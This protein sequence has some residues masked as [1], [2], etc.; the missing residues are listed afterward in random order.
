MRVTFL[1]I[2]SFLFYSSSKAFI[3]TLEHKLNVFPLNSFTSQKGEEG[4]EEDRIG[5]PIG[6]LPTVSSRIN[7]QNRSKR[8]DACD[9]WI[10]GAGTIGEKVARIW[11]Q[12]NPES[13]VIAETKSSTR[14]ADLMLLG[15][16]PRLREYR[17]DDDSFIAKNVLICIPPSAAID[18][19]AEL[20]AGC[21][22]WDPL[23][24]GN[25]VFT[26]S[27][28][29]Y[30]DS[31][32]NI[33]NEAFRVDS[34]SQRSTKM[35][36]AEQTVLSL[37][38]TVA[39]LAGLYTLERGAHSMWVK[40]GTVTGVANGVVNLVHYDDAAAALVAALQLELRNEVYLVCD[41]A[42]ETRQQICEAT[43]LSELFSSYAM[44]K[45]TSPDGPRGK[46]CD[47]SVTRRKLNWQPVHRSFSSFM[48]KIAGLPEEV[49]A[50][51]SESKG[52]AADGLWLPGD[53]LDFLV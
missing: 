25:L 30:G 41:D 34:R 40:N 15:G 49:P 9:L 21:R 27:T 36:S 4:G 1:N 42:A 6:P 24:G 14:H 39:R 47:S 45:F 17:T 52:P 28:A 26:S 18:Y 35:L 5:A 53:D 50:Q 29:V 23:W 43:L 48:R 51:Q 12:K 32:G 13:V 8:L 33:V 19:D 7:F 46:V 20:A 2:I 10:V 16:S 37:G 11:K 31:N 22:L 44:P 38:G 3:I